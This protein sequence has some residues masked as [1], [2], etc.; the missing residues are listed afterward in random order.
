MPQGAQGTPKDAAE[1]PRAASDWLFLVA[2]GLLDSS[3]ALL[4]KSTFSY[5]NSMVLEGL[6]P[7]ES[8]LWALSSVAVVSFGTSLRRFGVLGSS[9]EGLGALWGTGPA[10]LGAV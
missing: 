9:A 2:K 4:Q 10:V 5:V 7:P 3:P 8:S 6:G 1:A